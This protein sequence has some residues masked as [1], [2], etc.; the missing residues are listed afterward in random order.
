MKSIQK[1]S[2]ILRSDLGLSKITDK[3]DFLDE[4]VIKHYGSL[5]PLTELEES[6]LR[7]NQKDSTASNDDKESSN[8]DNSA[9]QTNNQQNGNTGNTQYNNDANNQSQTNS[10]Q[11]Y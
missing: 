3:D 11:T 7:K 2:N 10:A 6:L 5:V 1:Y 8:Q 4:R 9:N